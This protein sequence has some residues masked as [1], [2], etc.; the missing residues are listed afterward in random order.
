[1]C[2][3]YVRVLNDTCLLLSQVVATTAGGF[4]QRTV[5]M[6]REATASMLVKSLASA[7]GRGIYA[8]TFRNVLLNDPSAVLS[9]I[10]CDKG[11][12]KV[13]V[14]SC[15]YIYVITLITSLRTLLRA[16]TC[17]FGLRK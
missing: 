6:K 1:M 9:N 14:W 13:Q 15:I 8:V 11:P 2:A 3:Y 16:F 7:Y 10:F 17:R 12:F 5:L 4:Q